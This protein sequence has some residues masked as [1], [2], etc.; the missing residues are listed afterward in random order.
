MPFINHSQYEVREQ[1]YLYDVHRATATTHVTQRSSALAPNVRW[2]WRALSARQ[3]SARVSPALD[4]NVFTITFKCMYLRNVNK[5]SS[6]QS[7]SSGGGSSL[8]EVDSLAETICRVF[9]QTIICKEGMAITPQRY[10]WRPPIAD[11]K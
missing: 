8:E 1:S 7:Y 11:T 3:F 9:H 10:D 5:F 6:I 2:N 4:E